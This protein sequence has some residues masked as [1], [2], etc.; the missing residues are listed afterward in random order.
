MAIIHVCCIWGP[1]PHHSQKLLQAI[2]Q[3]NENGCN[4]FALTI[5]IAKTEIK[6]VLHNK[7]IVI[8]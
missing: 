5:L 1:N 3:A 2:P 8:I 6:K 4:T 7:K